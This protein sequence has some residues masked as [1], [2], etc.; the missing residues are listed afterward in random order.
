ML[1]ATGCL[2]MVTRSFFLLCLAFSSINTFASGPNDPKVNVTVVQKAFLEKIPLAPFEVVRPDNLTTRAFFSKDI[3]DALEAMA[4]ALRKLMPE[5]QDWDQELLLVPG[6]DFVGVGG[7]EPYYWEAQDGHAILEISFF[8]IQNQQ[9]EK[10][11]TFLCSQIEKMRQHRKLL[12]QLLAQNVHTTN[13]LPIEAANTALEQILKVSG[14]MTWSDL[15]EVVLL[16]SDGNRRHV[17]PFIETEEPNHWVMFVEIDPFNMKPALSLM[18][19]ELALLADC[20]QL[21]K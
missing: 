11:A 7:G 6:L 4:P 13:H 21:L 17:A 3:F 8:A 1:Y 9:I 18:E 2:C 10:I 12:G 16:S 20:E 5:A 14:K 15:I 19:A